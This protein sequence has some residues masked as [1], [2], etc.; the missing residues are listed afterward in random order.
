MSQTF[1]LPD[2]L[3]EQLRLIAEQRGVSIEQLLTQWIGDPAPTRGVLGA[4]DQDQELLVACTRAL[5]DGRDP[6]I[7][8]DWIEIQN[9]LQA[10]EPFYATVEEAMSAL[11]RRPWS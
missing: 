3:A 10:S 6:P 5:L 7:A 9:A 8:I 2:E 11:R 4:A 1:T